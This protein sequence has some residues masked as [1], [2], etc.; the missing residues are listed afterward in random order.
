M[1][2]E[3]PVMLLATSLKPEDPV[4]STKTLYE[5]APVT[6]D[7]LMVICLLAT[8]MIDTGAAGAVG[9]PEPPEPPDPEPLPLPDP[10]PLPWPEPEPG[11]EPPPDTAGDEP[12]PPPPHAANITASNTTASLLF[13]LTLLNV[14]L[15]T[16]V[17]M[18]LLV[19]Y[20]L[21]YFHLK[22]KSLNLGN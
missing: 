16:C 5:V 9:E 2:T 6:G 13:I 19:T 15:Y 1:L 18:T 22:K 11:L 21:A 10:D 8:E 3:V 14:Q 4:G 12:P 7:Q 17:R 20:I